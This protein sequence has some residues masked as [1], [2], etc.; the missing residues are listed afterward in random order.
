MQPAQAP[1]ATPGPMALPC[2]SDAQCMTHKCNMQFQKCAFPCETDNDCVQG[3]YCFKGV[4][5]GATCLPKAPGQ[6]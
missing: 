3:S 1:L 2:Q 4:P 6:Q 5:T